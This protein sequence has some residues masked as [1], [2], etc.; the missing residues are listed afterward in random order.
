MFQSRFGVEG[1][2]NS[3][4]NQLVQTI[5]NA[6]GGN[7][8]VTSN[9]KEK[10]F[11]AEVAAAYAPKEAAYNRPAQTNEEIAALRAIQEAARLNEI[12][13]V[14]GGARGNLMDMS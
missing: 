6:G 2:R 9:T 3:L 10:D 4:A 14:V 5:L 13:K 11:A 8:P 12:R 1:D 7:P